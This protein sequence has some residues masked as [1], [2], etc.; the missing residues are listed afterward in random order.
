MKKNKKVESLALF[1]GE[2]VRKSYLP[3]AHQWFD[4]KEIHKV[5]N[6]LKSEWVTTGPIVREFES[7]FANYV[8]AKYAV[9][10]NSGT[11]ALHISCLSLGLKPNDEVITTPFTF[12][13]TS[14]AILYCGA[15]PV[16]VDIEP[17]T[18]N[19]DPNKIKKSI[20]R[21]TKGIIPVHFAGHPCEMDEIRYIAKKYGL[22]ILE[23]AAHAFSAKYKKNKIGS[24][25]QSTI[26]SFHPVKNITTGEGGMVATN[27]SKFY[28]KLMM[29]RTHGIQKD[30][31]TRKG[32]RGDWYYNMELLGYRYNMTELQAALGIC[33]LAKIGMFQKR[34]RIIVNKYNK[35]FSKLSEWMLPV[36]RKHVISSWHLYI[37]RQSPNFSRQ[38]THNQ[39]IRAIR[40]ENVGV[41]LHYK[42]IYYH[43]YYKKRF[44]I[45]KGSFPVC[46]DNYR[47]IITLP[48][49]PKMSIKDAGDVI[50]SIRKVTK[51][52]RNK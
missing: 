25:S 7:K 11:A 36:E 13:A 38:V 22:W 17:D 50:R 5:I 30:A 45:K 51:Y 42:P 6:V 10:V 28:Q 4:Q 26:F 27:D 18:L 47:R 48:L 16:F 1:G 29:Y 35:E 21:K 49:F 14:N 31:W 32:S 20:T 52:Y 24:L 40:A 39:L 37:L 46:E 34:R 23:D 33:Q 3:Y 43:P 9:S 2:P 41:Q 12:I 15:K 8:D 44:H 19:L